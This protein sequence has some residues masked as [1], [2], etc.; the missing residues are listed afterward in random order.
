[1][2]YTN[3]IRV[4]IIWKSNATDGNLPLSMLN[5]STQYSPFYGEVAFHSNFYLI[6]ST[7][8]CQCKFYLY[9]RLLIKFSEIIYKDEFHIKTHEVLVS[10]VKL[11][12]SIGMIVCLNIIWS[13]QRRNTFTAQTKQ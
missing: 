5:H 1:M 6:S 3:R 4:V 10:H 12:P 8:M 11:I 9:I 7:L 13:S 2:K